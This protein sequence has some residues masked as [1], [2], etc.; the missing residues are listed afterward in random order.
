MKRP[1]RAAVVAVLAFAVVMLIM[2][3]AGCGKASPAQINPTYG[4][5]GQCFEADH[6]PCDDDPFDTDDWFESDHK[7]PTASPKAKPKPTP[8]KTPATVRTPRRR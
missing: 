8:V 1:L 3:A 6:E 4:V 7:K 2:S 5:N